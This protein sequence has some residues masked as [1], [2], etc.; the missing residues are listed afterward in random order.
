MTAAANRGKERASDDAPRHLL[1]SPGRNLRHRPFSCFLFHGVPLPSAPVGG[2][3]RL[4]Y[5]VPPCPCSFQG[6]CGSQH[7]CFR[8]GACHELHAHR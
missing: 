8:E 5:P 6:S 3:L 4:R 7:G 1:V 2:H